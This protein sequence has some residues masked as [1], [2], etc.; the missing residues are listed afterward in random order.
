MGTAEEFEDLALDGVEVGVEDL[1]GAA[2]EVVAV[3]A[4]QEC[5]DGKTVT[6]L[7]TADQRPL[8]GLVRQRP[9][10]QDPHHRARSPLT[11]HTRPSRRLGPPVSCLVRL[12]PVLRPAASPSRTSGGDGAVP[13]DEFV[14][15]PPSVVSATPHGRPTVKGA[16]G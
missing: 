2:V 12:H 10:A 13:T 14:G 4:A 6:K 8:P 16:L 15:A 9:Q 1:D 7:L 3:Q 5:S 11:R